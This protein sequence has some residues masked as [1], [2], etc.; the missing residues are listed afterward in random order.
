VNELDALGTSSKSKKDFIKEEALLY[1]TW[2]KTNFA[3]LE[4]RE[5]IS[6]LSYDVPRVG[7]IASI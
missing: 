5:E 4:H 7:R 6:I 3:H 2:S 1:A